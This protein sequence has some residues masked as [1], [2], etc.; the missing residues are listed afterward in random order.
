M[1]A[2]CF[3]RLIFVGAKSNALPIG[4]HEP[5]MKANFPDDV[6]GHFECPAASGLHLTPTTLLV[7]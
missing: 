6:F 7:H 2:H 3:H 1:F 5:L 4:K